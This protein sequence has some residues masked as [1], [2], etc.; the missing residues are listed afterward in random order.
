MLWDCTASVVVWQECSWR[1]QKLSLREDDGLGWFLQLRDRLSGE[2]LT[3][4]VIVAQFIWLRQ[5]ASVFGKEV[6]SPF[7]VVQSAQEALAN[8]TWAATK[9][10]GKQHQPAS[11]VTP[12]KPPV[13]GCLKMN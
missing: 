9:Q 13:L 3:E 6:P 1:V 7:Q 5:N 12:W 2:E 8:F 10:N 4:A 11:S